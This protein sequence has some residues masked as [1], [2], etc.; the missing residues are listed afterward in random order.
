[1]KRY[2]PLLI[3]LH[4][5]LA[6][7]IIFS[8]GMGVAVLEEIPNSDPDKLAYLQLHMTMGTLIL[9]LMAVRFIVRILKPR[10]A[11]VESGNAILDR[12]GPLIHKLFYVVVIAMAVSGLAVSILTDLPQILFGGSGAPLPENFHA[13]A[14]HA[15]HGI[16]GTVLM[17][18]I[19]LH[20]AGFIF[21]QFI[22]RDNLIGRMWFGRNA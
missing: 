17:A 5:L 20:L 9:V 4:W 3:A 15:V 7:M 2:H 21:R 16:L 14:P 19:L 10:P 6:V 13:V 8:L 1:M 12:L 22:R 18:M 11:P